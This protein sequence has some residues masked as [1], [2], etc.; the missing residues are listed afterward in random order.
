[1]AQKG[2]DN[3]ED[4][5]GS[6]FDFMFA[7]ANKP[8][9]KRK[10]IKPTGVSGSSEF[11]DALGMVLENPAAF[12]S[13]TVIDGMNDAF[14]PSLIKTQIDTRGNEM[15][16]K[17]NDI[18]GILKDPN[19]FFKKQYDTAK[20]KRKGS[21]IRWMA[22]A[23]QDVVTRAYA[24]KLGLSAE[25]G[26]ILGQATRRAM[27]EKG[28]DRST[29]DRKGLKNFN[30]NYGLGFTGR[31]YKEGSTDDLDVFVGGLQR[32]DQVKKYGEI[33][34]K[35]IDP[36]NRGEY[37]KQMR[38]FTEKLKREG[39]LN[40]VEWQN[41]IKKE[42]GLS[43][44]LIT[45]INNDIKTGMTSGVRKRPARLMNNNYLDLLGDHYKG[46]ADNAGSE[47][48][49]VRNQTAANMVD[50]LKEQK[51]MSRSKDELKRVRQQIKDKRRIDSKHPDLK[52][53]LEEEKMWEQLRQVGRLST[54]GQ[55][56]GMKQSWD[57]T[58]RT[59]KDLIPNML[60]GNFYNDKGHKNPLLCPTK[61]VA[62]NGVDVHMSVGRQG[63]YNE[64]FS[65]FLTD[66]YYV[67]PAALVSTLTTG[68][69]FAR[70]LHKQR[71]GIEV[72]I[73]GLD[74]ETKKLFKSL[75]VL[76]EK[77]EFSIKA[78]EALMTGEDRDNKLKPIMD[79]I[80][81]NPDGKFSKSFVKML[82]DEDR[83]GMLAHRFGTISR[84]TKKT[85]L[86]FKQN[87]AKVLGV[88][89]GGDLAK[90]SAGGIISRFVG[91]KL[92]TKGTQE[93][94]AKRLGK[95][96]AERIG[97][98]LLEGGLKVG[99][100]AFIES[101]LVAGS[102]IAGTP[103]A[104]AIVWV[105][106]EIVTEIGF[107]LIGEI[108]LLIMLL[109]MGV[110]GIMAVGIGGAF[111]IGMWGGATA[112]D[113][114]SVHSH[115]LPTEIEECPAYIPLE[116]DGDTLGSLEALREALEVLGL[117][118][119]EI[120]LILQEYQANP[121]NLSQILSSYGLTQSQINNVVAQVGTGT[122]P[123]APF[124]AGALPAGETCL[125]GSGGSYNCTQGAY[126]HWSHQNVAANDYG[127]L[128]Y[129]HAPSF[130]GSGNCTVT[131]NGPIN[132]TAG[133]AGDM[134]KFT[135][136]YGGT[137]YEFKL[138]HVAS[139]F[140]VGQSIGSGERVARIMTFEETGNACSSGA[141]L[142]LETKV[143]GATVDPYEVMTSPSS[144]GGFGCNIST[145]PL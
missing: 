118:A 141:H 82:K 21:H 131:F 31:T 78:W 64:Q 49:K 54:L 99:L 84:F 137:T 4:A 87:L 138:I 145:C 56:E 104:G 117:T 43:P 72:K 111:T 18:A 15:E 129:F 66:I 79:Y 128:G 59:T 63:I 134:V 96:A 35:N 46:K 115:I 60:N 90:T 71:K 12:V 67:T 29:E 8:P 127:Y 122:G 73:L 123:L 23:V 140:S 124:E 109:V 70:R 30:Q 135:A 139:N 22:P 102:S 37:D 34:R 133:Y 77:G 20:L 126:G 120:N 113:Y 11:T 68:E 5:L 106:T 93:F 80:A 25:D 53:L 75:D 39:A 57:A 110:F 38:L 69:G 17:A 94:F 19:A 143:N 51:L 16:I 101:I 119:T 92:W 6:I 7:E 83:L 103:L 2:Q 10:P 47:D 86:I 58:M 3:Y 107:K 130:C 136:E 108:I 32:N 41:F 132:C 13:D 116:F 36:S 89:L 76:N 65:E 125:L 62:V 28:Y 121:G 44:S 144:Q 55:L 100:K 1:M 114:M 42:S 27:S 52:M 74:D 45:S 33:L 97:K 50:A 24:K 48:D 105:A 91:S 112:S 95:E 142:H 61:N 26:K 88:D 14:N 81:K 98:E 9:D 40:P 85:E